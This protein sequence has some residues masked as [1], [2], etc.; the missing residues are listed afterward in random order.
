MAQCL[1]LQENKQLTGPIFFAK[2][3]VAVDRRSASR[4]KY[5]K[6]DQ[7]KSAVSRTV[8]TAKAQCLLL[9]K[10]QLKG[11]GTFAPESEQQ[12]G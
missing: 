2:I 11:A 9:E 12:R 3:K 5:Q 7:L 4:Q 6:I 8:T 10:G 1:R